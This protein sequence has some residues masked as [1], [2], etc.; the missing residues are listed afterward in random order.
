MIW[1]LLNIRHGVS[2]L[3]NFNNDEIGD[4]LEHLFDNKLIIIIILPSRKSSCQ[5]SVHSDEKWLRYIGKT[6]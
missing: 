4:I 1:E 2:T 6:D 3:E 5:I